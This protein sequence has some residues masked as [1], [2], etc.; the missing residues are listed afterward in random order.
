MGNRRF[1]VNNVDDK[2]SLLG[3][4]LRELETKFHG[5][6][7]VDELPVASGSDYGRQFNVFD[8]APYVTLKTATGYV[9]RV[10]PSQKIVV[11]VA[12][13]GD[14]FPQLLKT[15]NDDVDG[16]FKEID[17]DTRKVLVSDDVLPYPAASLAGQTY[18]LRNTGRDDAYCRCFYNSS[19]GW[20]WRWLRPADGS[21]EHPYP[22]L[23][24]QLIDNWEELPLAWSTNDERVTLSSSADAYEGTYSLQ[25]VLASG[26]SVS[27][28]ERNTNLATA[29]GAFGVVHDLDGPVIYYYGSGW[30]DGFI[31]ETVFSVRKEF[32]RGTLTTLPG[33]IETVCKI[34][35]ISGPIDT[36]GALPGTLIAT[37]DTVVLSGATPTADYSFGAGVNLSS[38]GYD[39]YNI[40][41]EEG[42]EG[43][44]GGSARYS[45]SMGYDNYDSYGFRW[46]NFT[47]WQLRTYSPQ[48]ELTL[49]LTQ[50]IA[51][52][53]KFVD[54]SGRTSIKFWVK[55][56]SVTGNILEFK[57]GNYT[58]N[59]YTAQITVTATGVWE[60][61]T[62]DISA[63]S[64][65]VKAGLQYWSF[66]WGADASDV[67]GNAI[68]NTLHIDFLRA[69]Y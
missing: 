8:D 2:R 46:N 15:G 30:D 43:T 37:S 17:R 40:V 16:M 19:D 10:I 12:D 54:C 57:Y 18:L 33:T 42:E 5:R 61:K 35:G 27:V 68:A 48:F 22:E 44:R 6:G 64:E 65:S 21:L 62:V 23:N 66:A 28:L 26:L 50:P 29:L 13:L 39:Y 14:G 25:A 63:L 1:G 36:V 47:G 38:Y 58:Y 56:D 45:F 59:D 41:L 9:N 31:N 53:P 69:E 11:P 67:Y 60:E 34:Y 52:L 24:Y 3:Y 20:H 7:I 51:Q 55:S 4:N 49:G 32:N